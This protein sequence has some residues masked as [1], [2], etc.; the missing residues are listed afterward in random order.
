MIEG[1]DKKV[2]RAGDKFHQRRTLA[3]DALIAPSS[4]LPGGADAA[5]D[6]GTAEDRRG[7]CRGEKKRRPK[8]L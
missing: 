6:H 1:S 8:P 4:S 5:S 7:I 3:A 2:G